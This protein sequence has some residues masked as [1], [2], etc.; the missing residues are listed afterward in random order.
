MK[1]IFQ[2]SWPVMAGMILQS[3]LST[4]DMMFVGRLGTTQLAA[5]GMSNSTLTI[6]FVLSTLVSSGVIAL[7]SRYFGEGN[8]DMVKKISSQSYIISLIL[9]LICSIICS[10]YAKDIFKILYSP[11]DNTLKY[12]YQ[13]SVI[14]FSGSVFV[15]ISSTLR[16]ILQA[17]GN[18][19]LPL[20]I[21]GFA[22]ILNI[23]LDYVFI[24]ELN[25]GVQGAA[26]ATVFSN[27][28]SFIIINI[29]VINELY[30]GKLST[31]IKNIKLSKD[32][33]SKILKIGSW[34]CIKEAAR[35]FTGMLM[36]S[37]VYFVGK[38]SSSAAFSAGQ[39]I[40]NY[41]FIFLNGLS[42]AISIMVGQ[43]MGSGDIDECYKI[44]NV[45]LKL[46][47]I[48]MSVFFIPYFIFPQY[49]MA[50]F[51]ND[52]SVIN[53]GVYYLRIVYIG[54]VFV[55][56]PV[57][58]GGVFQGAGDTK[59]P[60]IASLLSNVVLKLPLA[61][62][63]AVIFDMG[64]NGVWLAISLSVVIEAVIILYYFKKDKWKEIVV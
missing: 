27:I 17:L 63:L 25:L 2:L 5:V 64:T 59:P 37:L 44:I 10:I 56:F 55:I 6:I 62:L 15:F 9:G 39:Q 19:K 35:P 29:V 14:V 28:V 21:F 38:E 41:T 60:M 23:I 54:L 18:T 46:A 24:Y 45:G 22:N 49:I 61:Y 34:A 40:L 16:T 48:N 33:V 53:T 43:N 4:V 51:T 36:V 32:V 11:D 50:M 20:Y 1:K 52:I 58:L 13:F 57:I 42:V 3:L 12:A 8:A 30:E 47:C 31:F 7:I 26:L